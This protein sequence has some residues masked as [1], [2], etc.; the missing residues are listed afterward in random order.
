MA[1]HPLREAGSNADPLEG[2]SLPA[3]TYSDPE[4][5]EIEKQRVFAPS[6]QV[7]CH[8]SDIPEPGDWHTLDY[9][10]ES[11]VVVGGT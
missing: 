11:V 9:I 8:V 3:W 6:W 1:T 5:F 2:W 4:F 10:G 7:V